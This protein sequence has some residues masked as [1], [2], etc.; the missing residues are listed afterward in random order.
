[1]IRPDLQAPELNPVYAAMLLGNAYRVGDPDT[2]ANQHTPQASALKGTW[3]LL[4]VQ[5]TRSKQAL[6]DLCY[7][8][9]ALLEIK[10]NDLRPHRS[11]R[12]T[13]PAGMRTPI[14]SGRDGMG[15]RQGV[16]EHLAVSNIEDVVACGEPFAWCHQRRE[17]SRRHSDEH[18]MHFECGHE[19][20][21]PCI[22]STTFAQPA[23]PAS[24]ANTQTGLQNVQ[25]PSP[26]WL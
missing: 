1:V 7:N 19:L 12:S 21:D 4:Y 5:A 23:R 11:R 17:S 2:V 8:Q 14:R 24:T 6:S 10:G 9:D 20:T 13:V 16:A 15:T 3:K 22:R 18:R 26:Q 25:S